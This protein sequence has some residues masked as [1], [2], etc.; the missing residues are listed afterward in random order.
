MIKIT[1]HQ[2]RS[3][4][5]NFCFQMKTPT[6]ITST[7]S[8]VFKVQLYFDLTPWQSVYNV[9]CYLYRFYKFKNFYVRMVSF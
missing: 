6:F 2:T 3:G 1:D 8:K 4:S 5:K 9:D 7:Y